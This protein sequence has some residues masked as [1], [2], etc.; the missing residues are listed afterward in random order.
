MF[1]FLSSSWVTIT[2]IAAAVVVAAS[3]LV[4]L[5]SLLEKAFNVE[6]IGLR[7]MRLAWRIVKFFG[8]WACMPVRPYMDEVRDFAM[9]GV[10][11]EEKLTALVEKSNE[12]DIERNVRFDSLETSL[13]NIEK[14]VTLNGGGSIKDAVTRLVRHDGG[15]WD[16]MVELRES[17]RLTNLRLDILDESDKRL[18]FRMSAGLECTSI[19]STFLRF[20]GYT[21]QDMIGTDWEFCIADRSRAEVNMK[22]QRSVQ[23][24]VQYRN[25]QFIVDSDGKEYRCLVRGYPVND[26]DGQ[27]SGFY[28]TV[29]VID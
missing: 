6:F 27:F 24:R 19:S 20:F 5:T 11:I 28:G 14:E 16:I 7:T 1:E 8:R 3:G 2:T 17:A 25:E 21:E 13:F 4:V 12:R 15:T 26:V 9:R 10:H 29:E 22:W 23:K 18:H